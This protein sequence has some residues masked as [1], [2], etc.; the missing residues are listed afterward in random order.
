MA[1]LPAR[2]G[3]ALGGPAAWHRG[4]YPDGPAGGRIGDGVAAGPACAGDHRAALP[5]ARPAHGLGAG[6][7]RNHSWQA[8]RLYAAGAGE[9]APALCPR[10]DRHDLH[11]ALLSHHGAACRVDG[12]AVARRRLT[13]QTP[14]E[15]SQ[16]F[17]FT[18]RALVLGA[19]QG[20]IGLLLAAR[21]EEHTSELQ[22]LMRTSYAVLCLNKKKKK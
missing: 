10:A 9:P 14:T 3:R 7:R 5:L 21:S 12:A 4:R 6:G 16:Q 2:H 11:R 17:S 1:S 22:S 18:R 19:A 8:D 20:G 13:P 15:A